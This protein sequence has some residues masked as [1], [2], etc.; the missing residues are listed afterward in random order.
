MKKII[1]LILSVFVLSVLT[2]SPIYADMAGGITYLQSHQDNTGKIS[3]FGGES[4]WAA[5]GF[6]ENGIDIST[7]K[8]SGVSLK[9][10]LLSDIPPA[11]AAATEWERRIL[12]IVATGGDP[13]NFGGTNY[14][15]QVELL[16]NNNQ[17]GDTALLNDDIFGLLA[18]IASG[19]TAQNEIKQSVLSFII[20]H[21]NSDGGFSWS[22]NPNFNTS[23]SNDTAA[24]LQALQAAQKDGL[25]HAELASSLEKAKNY[26]LSLQSPNGG[27]KYDTSEWSTD[28]DSASTAW[29]LMALNAMDLSTSIEASNAKIWLN[30]QQETDGGFHW[31]SGSGSDTATTSYALIALSGNG[32]LYVPKSA[33]VIPA[34]TISITPTP[35]LTSSSPSTSVTPTVTP[36][37]QCT[38]AAPPAPVITAAEIVNETTVKLNWNKISEPM[39]Y[40]LLAY[41]TSEENLVYGNPNIGGK[42][43]T[44]YTVGSL[45]TGK[46]YY[47]KI[48]AGNGCRAGDFSNA[49]LVGLATRRATVHVVTPTTPLPTIP[50]FQTPT[51]TD[52]QE[53]AEVLG[54]QTGEVNSQQIPFYIAMAITILMSAVFYWYFKLKR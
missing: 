13:T 37:Q 52:K 31:M 7:V 28:P 21:Q 23:D 24:A 12:A 48:R 27:F 33:A 49:A 5:I 19:S 6:A 15:Q 45:S 3:G 53:K 25:T 40:Y 4:Q 10:Y 42:D 14:V 39:T 41:G 26:L 47:F 35:T 20:S 29:A 43:L 51:M 22:T 38:D 16:A 8:Q 36:S 46:T 2:S 9:D 50:V 11:G 30:A 44:S 34:P 1:V 32:L 18:L 54:A 17:L